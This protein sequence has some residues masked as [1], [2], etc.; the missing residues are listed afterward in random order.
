MPSGA[1]SGNMAGKE[2]MNESL[3]QT[4]EA[5][6][7]ELYS[8][9]CEQ[10]IV[11]YLAPNYIEHQ[12]TAQFSREGLRDYVLGRLQLYPAHR[13]AIHHVLGEGDFIFLFVEEKLGGSLDVARAELFRLEGK[14]IVEHWGAQVIDEKNRKNPN[15]TFDGT[16]VN[17]QVDYARRQ[18]QRFE[19][20]DLQGFN[21]QI[22]DSFYESRVPEYR[23]HSPKGGDGRDGLVQI[24]SQLKANGQKMT[25]SPKR[26]LVDGDFIVCH[27]LYD[28]DPPHP[29]I[30]RINTFDM[31][32][33][34]AEGKAV[35]HWDV[36]EDVPSADLLKRIF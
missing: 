27:R 34:N 22:L 12:F 1:R 4:V 15:G 8:A 32:R 9:R 36:M 25:M 16:Q 2:A 33:L 28:S 19:A 21:A 35:E 24:L 30:N 11:R 17:R 10:A 23:Q 3:R 31:F 18:V 6:Y 7:R 14:L 20:L 5:Y 26:V 13:I 29:L